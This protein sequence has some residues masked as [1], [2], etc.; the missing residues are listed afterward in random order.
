[1]PFHSIQWREIITAPVLDMWIRQSPFSSDNKADRTAVLVLMSEK[2]RRQ[3]NF[4]RADFGGVL[5][6][7]TRRETGE[8]LQGGMRSLGFVLRRVC[9]HFLRSMGSG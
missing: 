8:F 1:M 3:Q 4:D 7:E 5:I 9:R 6:G 2:T